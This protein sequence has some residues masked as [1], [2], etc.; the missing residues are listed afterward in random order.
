MSTTSIHNSTTNS[1]RTYI[2]AELGRILHQHDPNAIRIY[3]FVQHVKVFQ[4]NTNELHW[5][6]NPQIEGNLFAY[7]KQQMINN[8]RSSVFAFAV[9]NKEEHL[10]E[11]IPLN[12]SAQAD[13]QY[14]FY[15][16]V[17]NN[18]CQVYSLCFLNEHECQRCYTFIQRSIQHTKEQQSRT[19]ISN[20]PQI[21]GQVTPSNVSR[22]Q[23]PVHVSL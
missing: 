10:I 5:E 20:T 19:S 22:Q 6:I 23:T 11:E 18:Q 2:Q 15:E 13:K 8:Q 3:D 17:R 14:L 21:N 1:S 9:I 7:E 12:I 4:Y 16:L